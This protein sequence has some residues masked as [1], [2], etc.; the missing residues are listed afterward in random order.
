MVGVQRGKMFELCEECQKAFNFSAAVAPTSGEERDIPGGEQYPVKCSASSN[1]ADD[2]IAIDEEKFSLCGGVGTSPVRKK[3]RLD[4]GSVEETIFR[5]EI[6]KVTPAAGT[7]SGGREGEEEGAKGEMEERGEGEASKEG[8]RG[9][10]GD[11]REGEEEEEER[12]IGSGSERSSPKTEMEGGGGEKQDETTESTENE[13]E[14]EETATPVCSACL[15]LLDESFIENLST[16]IC[17][18]LERAAYEHVKS[19]ALSISTPLSL[20]IRRSAVLFYLKGNFEITDE[21]AQPREAYVKETLR[22]KLYLKLKPKLSHLKCDVESQFQ[23]VLKL[24]HSSYA[25]DCRLAA[26]TWP[27]IFAVPKKRRGRRWQ[28]KK[29]KAKNSSGFDDSF[30]NT[31]KLTNALSVA[32]ESDFENVDFLSAVRPC[33]Y[34]ISFLRTPIFV[35]G[36]YCKYSRALPQTPWVVDGVRKVETSVQELICD[37]ILALV[38]ASQQRFSSSGREDCDVRMLGDGRPFLVELINPKRTMLESS[39]VAELQS[40]INS[41]TDLVEVKRLRVMAKADAVTLKEGE[42]KKRKEYRALV[43]APEDVTQED[44]DR[45]AE[46][47]ETVLHQ[48]TP[49]RVLHRRA[50]ATRDRSV[51]CMQGELVGAHH[52]YLN[53]TTQAGTYVKEF[54]HSDFGRTRPNLRD[55]MK[56]EVDIVSL[57]VCSVLLDWPPPEP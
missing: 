21:L 9:G 41:S 42:A 5:K 52:F 19:F 48:K 14:N 12:N 30:F 22:H 6:A 25:A 11:E 13:P 15:G 26:K 34:S 16:D 31:T 28:H 8:G 27:S 37:H 7:V 56:Q 43:Y 54:V 53:L 29:R 32:T 49:I 45:L 33:S 20:M 57:D 23:I 10:D 18:Q 51:Y 36:R 2:V 17:E 4:G 50:L 55:I 40:K 47:G 44:L 35:G 38:G 3:V 1:K 46:M 39:E 24:D